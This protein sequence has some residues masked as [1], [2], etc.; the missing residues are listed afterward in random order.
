MTAMGTGTPSMGAAGGSPPN[1]PGL[2]GN[3]SSPTNF[4][5]SAGLGGG[6]QSPR[7]NL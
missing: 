3:M 7:A 6:P 1:I 4:S 5:D 2:G